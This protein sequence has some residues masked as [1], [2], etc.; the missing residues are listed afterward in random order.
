MSDYFAIV[1]PSPDQRHTAHFSLGG[2]IRFGP[3]YYAL[4]VGDYSFGERIFGAPHLWSTS[5]PLIAVQEW[6][7]LV[8]SEGPITALVLI[9]AE[10]RREATVARAT[11]RFLVPEGFADAALTYRVDYGGQGGNSV[12]VDISTITAWTTLG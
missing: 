1:S 6:L 2:E 4:R 12:A 10:K 3:P 9:D 7:T 11:K 5:S 8:Y